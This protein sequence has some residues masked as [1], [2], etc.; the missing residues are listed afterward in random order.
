MIK[1]IIILHA[2][3]SLAYLC[4]TSMLLGIAGLKGECNIDCCVRYTD[5]ELS[6]VQ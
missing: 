3:I 2:A 5:S 4:L 1:F 6:R